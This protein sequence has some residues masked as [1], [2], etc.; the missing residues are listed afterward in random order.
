MM[1]KL[2]APFLNLFF[3][4]VNWYIEAL[5]W[6]VTK[7]VTSPPD[8]VTLDGLYLGTLRISVTQVC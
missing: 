7:G 8:N 2:L 5:H 3:R 6:A 1:M 4:Q